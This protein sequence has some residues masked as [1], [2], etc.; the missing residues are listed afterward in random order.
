VRLTLRGANPGQGPEFRLTWERQ[1]S[2][3]NVL[4]DDVRPVR[5]AQ[6]GILGAVEGLLP[7][8]LPASGRGTLSG[9]VGRLDT[10]DFGT[11]VVHGAWR[12]SASE[13][14]WKLQA[15]L[16]A[17]ASTLRT[18]PQMLFLLGGPG[19]LPGHEYRS[20]V[21]RRFWLARA[22]GTHPLRPPWVGIRAFAAFGATQLA[23]AE[24]PPG[25]RAHDSDGLRAS[26]GAGLSLGWDV[27]RLD[28]AR[29]LRDGRW[30]VVFSVD[31]R[32]QPWL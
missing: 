18:P 27:L 26:V 13:R 7:F 1:A 30:A 5:P 11:L 25:W 16:A 20:F 14:T 32:F 15:D 19:T 10:Q 29:G 4:S 22:E 2:A 3:T 31:P 28:F 12:T 21:G 9:T 23:G 6:D 17:G 24:P 8:P